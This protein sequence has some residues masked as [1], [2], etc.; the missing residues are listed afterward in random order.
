MKFQTLYSSISLPMIRENLR[1]FWSIPALSFLIYFLSGV[2]PILISYNN[3]NRVADYINMSLT[4]LQPFFMSAHLMMPITTAVIIFRYLQSTSSV[5]MMH[6]LPFSRI[7]LY[8]S[9]LISGLILIITPIIVNGI[10]LLIIAKPVYNIWQGDPETTADAINLFTR[11]GVLNWMWESILIVLVVYAISVFAGLVTANSIMHFGTAIGFNFL[12]PSLYAIFVYYFSLYLYGFNLSGD[13]T[14]NCLSISPFL[15][16]FNYNSNINNFPISHQVY[17]ILNAFILFVLSAF[18]YSRRKLEK[19]GESLAFQFLIPIICYLIAFFGM[20]LFGTWFSVLNGDNILYSYSG[21]LAGGVLFFIVGRMIVLKT[22]RVFNKSMLKSFTVYALISII[23]LTGLNFDITGFETRIPAT[24]RIKSAEIKNSFMTDTITSGYSGFYSN[25][26][27]VRSEGNLKLFDES[28]IASIRNLHKE[29]LNRREAF[30]KNSDQ[31][32]QY[33][34]NLDYMLGKY[35]NFQR[36]YSVDYY[37]IRDSKDL[38]NIYESLEY[39]SMFLLKNIDTDAIRDISF[40][41]PMYSQGSKLVTNKMEISKIADLLDKDYLNETYEEFV[42]L[43]YPRAYATI[44]FRKTNPDTGKT[45]NNSIN[46]PIKESYENTL[47]WLNEKGY[48]KGVVL[49]N[50]MISHISLYYSGSNNSVYEEKFAYDTTIMSGINSDFT[51]RDP[52]KIIEIMK[53]AKST[54]IS[55]SDYYYGTVFYRNPSVKEYGDEYATLSIYFNK[56]ETPDFIKDY[57]K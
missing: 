46:I 21:Y 54:N 7:K 23:F 22:P 38:K 10:I 11:S 57:F 27:A 40:S 31:M 9:N 44:N 8:T 56:E 28:N 50:D 52:E 6:S 34:T 20:T 24:E 4:N 48:L 5:T 17:Y 18:L 12:I 16:V 25:S 39:K 47:T 29:I 26:L 43:N 13:W 35:T 55:Y 49:E 45:I 2:F 15:E 30:D 1:R 41:D 42:N 53:F 36:V 37:F 19:A 33:R 14:S 32:V 51:V 3:I